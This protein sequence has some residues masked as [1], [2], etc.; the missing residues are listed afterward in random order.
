[1]ELTSPS[2]ES[3]LGHFYGSILA[4]VTVFLLMQFLLLYLFNLDLH[5][6][7]VTILFTFVSLWEGMN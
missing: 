2:S 3:L 7:K 5:E 4:S 6:G 1:M